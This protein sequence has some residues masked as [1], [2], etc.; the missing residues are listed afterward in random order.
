VLRLSSV[1]FCSFRCKGGTQKDARGH[2]EWAYVAFIYS[3]YGILLFVSMSF[4]LKSPLRGKVFPPIDLARQAK[5]LLISLCRLSH[6]KLLANDSSDRQS[7]PS[8]QFLQPG[9]KFVGKTDRQSV[10]IGML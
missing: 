8:R 10:L 5:E 9:Q 7:C 6:F 1:R 3:V 2:G 4:T